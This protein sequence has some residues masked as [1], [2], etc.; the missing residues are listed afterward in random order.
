MVCRHFPLLVV[1]HMADDVNT[2]KLLVHSIVSNHESEWP[3]KTL[4]NPNRPLEA[5]YLIEIFWVLKGRKR[6]DQVMEL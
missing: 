1:L 3:E 2:E 4:G 6:R 5:S